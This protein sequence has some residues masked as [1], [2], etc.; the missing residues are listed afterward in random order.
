MLSQSGRTGHKPEDHTEYDLHLHV[1]AR[2]HSQRRAISR[3]R[4]RHRSGLSPVGNPARSDVAMTGETMARGRVLPIG[5]SRKRFWPLI[6]PG[7]ER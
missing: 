4:H 7:Y 1:P 2:G 3:N 6:A 5:D